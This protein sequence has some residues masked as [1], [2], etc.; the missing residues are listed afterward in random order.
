MTSEEVKKLPYWKTGR[1]SPDEWLRKAI[2]EIDKVGGKVNESGIIRQQDN[3]VVLVGFKLEGDQ[4]RLV[5]PVLAHDPRENQ[6]AVRQAATMLYHDVKSRCVAAMVKGARW[7]FHAEMVLPNGM[8]AGS[9]SDGELMKCL[10]E[11]CRRP[12]AITHDES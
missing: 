3:E 12:L 11:M 5:W 7:A 9:L 2:R 10:P 1:S 4:F 8:Q 6:A